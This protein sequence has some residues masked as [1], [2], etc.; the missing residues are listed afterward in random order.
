MTFISSETVSSDVGRTV[1]IVI[2]HYQ[3]TADVVRYLRRLSVIATDEE[4]YLP[5]VVN[6]E[7]RLPNPLRTRDNIVLL[8]SES[9]VGYLNAC[10]EGINAVRERAGRH[11]TWWVVS[12]PDL[13]LSPSFFPRLLQMSPPDTLGVMAPDVRERGGRPC[14][15][16]LKC[17]PSPSWIRRRIRIFSNGV[18]AWLYRRASEGRRFLESPP[19]V[20]PDPRKIYAPHGSLMVFHRRFFECGGELAHDGFMYGEEIH[21]AEQARRC[22]LTVRWSP[23]LSAKHLGR[24]ATKH[25][26]SERTRQ[27]LLDSLRVLYRAHFDE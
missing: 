10:W 19:S 20:S 12:N 21:I 17:R 24:G 2:V 14:N 13:K 4:G 3:N 25:I 16:F 22:N 8:N 26:S 18:L 1:G 5:V 6:N 9:N 11:P 7:E 27:W 23:E 15:P